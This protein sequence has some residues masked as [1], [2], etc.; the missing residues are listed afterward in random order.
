[1]EWFCL[2]PRN[3]WGDYGTVLVSGYYKRDPGGRLLLHRAGPFLPPVSFPWGPEGH[4]LV[5][6][7][8]FRRA[9][10]AAGYTDLE[11]REAVKD[12]IVPL[13]WHTWDRSAATPPR[14]P[15]GGE[16]EEYIWDKRH[17]RGAAE[18]MPPAWEVVPPLIRLECEDIPELQHELV[19]PLRWVLPRREFPRWFRSREEYG[20]QILAPEA[21]AWVEQAAAEWVSFE[22]LRWRFAEPSYVLDH[23]NKNSEGGSV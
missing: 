23:L 2:R 12:R 9:L 11:F 13:D 3:L 1:M 8:D 10:I 16:P 6:S 20:D 5:V 4:R 15:P 21:R 7:D 18:Q 14:H 17:S 19:P 22:P